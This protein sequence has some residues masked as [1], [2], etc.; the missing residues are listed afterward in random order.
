MPE[1]ITNFKCFG[2]TG[3]IGEKKSVFLE[4]ENKTLMVLI[5]QFNHG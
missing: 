1:E 3:A 2:K 5:F 4:L